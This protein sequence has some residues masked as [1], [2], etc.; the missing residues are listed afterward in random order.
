[1]TTPTPAGDPSASS[2]AGTGIP[3]RSLTAWALIALAAVVVLFAFLHWVFPSF[4]RS[5]FV[6]GFSVQHFANL[7]VLVA[8][9]LAMLVATKLGPVLRHAKLMGMLALATYAAALLFGAV[10]FLISIAD[11]FDVGGRG[12]FHGFG[13]ILQ[14]LGSI[15]TELLLLALV[16]L[17]ALWTY[18]IY[19]G[20]GGKLPKVNL[21]ND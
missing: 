12:A 6:D 19:S 9:L 10:A 7:T 5:S 4:S 2:P 13:Y 17:A 21:Q 1:M 11:K 8:P 18:R 20:L 14:G 3:L 15:I 16:A